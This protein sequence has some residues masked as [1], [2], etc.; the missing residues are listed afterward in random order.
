MSERRRLE[1][2]TYQTEQI[3]FLASKGV[4]ALRQGDADTVEEC[5]NLIHALAVP[6]V[7]AALPDSVYIANAIH[8][9]TF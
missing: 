8:G 2:Q 7:A 3:Q 4:V 6:P 9:S 1:S 5:F